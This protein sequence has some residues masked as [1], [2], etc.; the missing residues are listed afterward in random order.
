MSS[1]SLALKGLCDLEMIGR[2]HGLTLR[3]SRDKMNESL[4]VET[5]DHPWEDLLLV[6]LTQLGLGCIE[7]HALQLQISEGIIYV[8]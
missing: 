3:K 2:S 7:H 8:L 5:A 4:T 1:T 6:F